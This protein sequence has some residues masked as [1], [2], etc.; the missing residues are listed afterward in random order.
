M[1]RS[2][3]Y[4]MGNKNIRMKWNGARK[5][6]GNWNKGF[7]NRDDLLQPGFRVESH[8]WFLQRLAPDEDN[9]EDPKKR[10]RVKLEV[11]HDHL[12]LCIWCSCGFRRHNKRGWV[13]DVRQ[14]G[15]GYKNYTGQSDD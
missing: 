5:V 6:G 9:N 10:I 14:K 2:L 11:D 7:L 4:K 15:K 12:E 3:K 8:K 1:M 13:G